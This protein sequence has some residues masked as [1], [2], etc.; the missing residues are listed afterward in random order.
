MNINTINTIP[1]ITRNSSSYSK[2]LRIIS[3]KEN[4]SIQNILE[5][6]KDNS[7]EK[8]EVSKISNTH[9]HDKAKEILEKRNYGIKEE[10]LPA[11]FDRVNLLVHG[12][13]S[14]IKPINPEGLIFRHYFASKE[15]ME[16]ALKDNTLIAGFTPYMQTSYKFKALYEDLTGVFLALPG[17]KPEDVGV[18]G[19]IYYIDLKLPIDTAV[20]E[21]EEGKIYLIPGEAKT[22][23]WI[24][25]AYN[26]YKKDK[27]DEIQK[28]LLPTLQEIEAKGGIKEA[29]KIK[30]YSA[31]SKAA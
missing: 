19:R 10:A 14:Y 26:K 11:C 12:A 2:S 9:T 28:D 21:I 29:L 27:K 7:L 18:P 1:L 8:I 3:R 23:E 22:P 15:H 30:F 4:S 20:L 17:V 13:P 31:C 25:E 5:L 16:S 6:S 24:I